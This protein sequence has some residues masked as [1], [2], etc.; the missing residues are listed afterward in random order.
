MGKLSVIAQVGR[1]A[2]ITPTELAGREGVK[3][4]TLT[5]MLAELETDGWLLREPHPVDGRQSVL[6]LTNKAKKRL[7]EAVGE[8]EAAFA[9]V[10]ATHLTAEE[11]A[12]LQKACALLDDLV[13]LI[14]ARTGK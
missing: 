11:R 1:S 13:D 12:L 5:R 8:S 9:K 2:G 3:I 4:Q 7:S 6:N 10:I 14:P